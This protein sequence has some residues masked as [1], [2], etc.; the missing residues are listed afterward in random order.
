MDQMA[1]KTEQGFV[2][3]EYELALLYLNG[4]NVK[5][6]LIEADKW[7]KRAKVS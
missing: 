3:A 5:Q 2:N 1:S 7:L 6:D 4:I